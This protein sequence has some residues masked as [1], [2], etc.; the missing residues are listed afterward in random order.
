MTGKRHHRSLQYLKYL[1]I[2]FWF[3][4]R[5][6]AT[7]VVLCCH[8]E[9]IWN[10]EMKRKEKRMNGKRKRMIKKCEVIFF[11][12]ST[13]LHFWYDWCCV[14]LSS[15]LAYGLILQLSPVIFPRTQPFNKINNKAI[16]IINFFSASQS[17]TSR[18]NNSKWTTWDKEQVYFL[19]IRRLFNYYKFAKTSHSSKQCAGCSIY[20][21]SKRHHTACQ[22][23]TF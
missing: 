18:T 22:K 6:H 17:R 20:C 14:P 1:K 3:F 7:Y 21:L 19:C 15:R 16:I 8:Y 11:M 9:Q 12:L 4:W 5:K 23:G 13:N 2:Y 10:W